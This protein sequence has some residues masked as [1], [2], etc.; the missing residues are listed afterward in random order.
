MTGKTEINARQIG[1][2]AAFILPVYKL[3]ETPSVLARYA[4]GDLLL[5]ALLHFILQAG[6]LCLILLFVAKGKTCL[7]D[8]IS[9]KIKKPLFAFFALVYLLIAILPVLDLEKFTYAVFY[10]T[11]PTLF[12]FAF[13][14]IFTAFVCVKELRS[15]GRAAD[16]S[17]FLFL[18]PFLALLVMSVTEADFTNLLPLFEYEFGHTVS[19][20]KNTTA[21]FTDVL[22]LLPLLGNLQYKK[23]D[24]KKIL[25]GYGLGAFFTL[26]FLAVFYGIFSSVAEREHYAFA[27]IAQYFPPLASIGRIDLIFVYILCIVLFF[28]TALPL[29]Y[30]TLFSTEIFGKNKRL[31]CAIL[32]NIGAFLFTLFFNKNYDFFYRF[33]GNTLWFVFLAALIP[34][35]FLC[36]KEKQ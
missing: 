35:C 10:D 1:L 3:V 31:L 23:G 12:S 2:F 22:L 4:K 15:V 11:P 21:H 16:L 13:F 36:R 33:L 18:V 7:Y 30:A 34:V 9:P 19:A 6:V 28:F 14:F 17:L 20:F 8:R 29:F 25:G 5:P 26:L 24:A 27:K 32:I